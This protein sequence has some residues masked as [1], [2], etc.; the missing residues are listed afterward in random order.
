ME[1][2]RDGSGVRN[3]HNISIDRIDNDVDYVESNVQLV[4]QAINI[5]KGTLE[6]EEFIR[7]C[8]SVAQHSA[9]R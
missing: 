3:P 6:D 7:L 2:F 9:G 1:N 4:C 5:M 8:K